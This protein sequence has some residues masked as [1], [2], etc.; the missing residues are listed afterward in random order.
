MLEGIFELGKEAGLIQELGCLELGESVSEL[1][2]GGFRDGLQECEANPSSE[3][4]ADWRRCFTAGG[5]RSIRAA[6]TA[7]TVAG[8]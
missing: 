5:S 8:T 6:S 7:C 3:T 4:A 1:K 2:I